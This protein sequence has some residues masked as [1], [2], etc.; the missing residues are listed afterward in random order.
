M[1]WIERKEI[2]QNNKVHTKKK[3][4]NLKEILK[5]YKLLRLKFPIKLGNMK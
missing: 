3:L 5:N 1:F 2:Y 4:I